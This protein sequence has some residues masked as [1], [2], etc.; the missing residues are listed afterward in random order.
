MRRVTRIALAGTATASLALA[1]SAC[2]G[3][4]TSSSSSD[5]KDGHKGLALA[6]DV[7]GKGDQSFNDAAYEGLK[8]AKG[9]FKYDTADVEPTDGETD[10]DKT[11]RLVSLAKQGYN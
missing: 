10:A 3:T 4:S 7:G 5:S 9:E 11:Q 2:G 8:K 6:Y 1:L